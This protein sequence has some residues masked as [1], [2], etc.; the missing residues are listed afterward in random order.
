MKKVAIL[1]SGG[2]APGMNNAIRAIAK[3]AKANNLEAYLVYEG[4]KG[5]Y[6]DKIVNADSI[7]LDFYLNQGGTCIYSARFPEFK[8]P[9]VRKV[10]LNNLKKRNI[11]A[12]VVI[13]GDGSYKGAQLLHEAGLKTIGLPGTIDNDI[14]SSDYTIGYD[15]ALNTIVDAIDRIR[16][17]ARSH[18]RIM[19]VEVMGNGCGDLALYSGLATGAEIIVSSQYKLTHEE[20][21]AKALELTKQPGRRSIVIVV[22]EKCYDIKQL[23]QD[24]QKATNWATRVNPLNHIQ[25]GG[26]PTAQER[27]LASLLGQKAIEYLLEGKSGLA[28]GIINNDIV[29]VPILEALSMDNLSKNKFVQKAI[30]FNKLNQIK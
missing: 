17:T 11:D 4:Y 6:N 5:L 7:D 12:L 3:H 29:G 16:D 14:A 23:E 8:E 25:R 9:E 1:T 19:I 30:K 15:T 28:I 24:V 26:K 21:A 27:I 10:A 22:S 2:D 20:I 13:G 18:K